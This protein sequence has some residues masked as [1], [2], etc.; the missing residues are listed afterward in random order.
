M[1]YRKEIKLECMHP[2]CTA[3][4]RWEVFGSGAGENYGNYCL[5]HARM[6]ETAVAELEADAAARQHLME[7]L[8]NE[9]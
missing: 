9:Q 2:G 8:G 6:K 5:R 7:R 3:K 1:S 4:A